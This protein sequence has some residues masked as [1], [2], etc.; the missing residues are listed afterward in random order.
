MEMPSGRGQ[1]SIWPCRAVAPD[2]DSCCCGRGVI[3]GIAAIAP[4]FNCANTLPVARWLGGSIKVWQEPFSAVP[5]CG[6]VLLAQVEKAGHVVSIRR[7]RT[8]QSRLVRVRSAC[9]T[10]A[11]LEGCCLSYGRTI[12]CSASPELLRHSCPV[13]RQ[14]V[15][16]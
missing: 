6:G 13:L 5:P 7:S 8:G 11:Y 16:R 15:P 14:M 9:T 10:G 4:R 12:P 3:I 1:S 2:Q